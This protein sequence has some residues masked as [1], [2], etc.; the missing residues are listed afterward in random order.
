MNRRITSLCLLLSLLTLPL[1]AQVVPSS[2]TPLAPCRIFSSSP[3]PMLVAGVTYLDLVR[4][5]CNVPQTANA[6]ALSMIAS[7]A[8]GAG[9]LK[10]W[11]SSDLEPPQASMTYRGNGNDSSFSI[12]RLCYPVEEC[13]AD[14]IA[15]KVLFADSHI[16]LDVQGYFEPSQSQSLMSIEEPILN[17]DTSPIPQRDP[18]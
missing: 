16:L 13:A 4:G 10:V 7:G 5:S 2:Y 17:W 1:A 6:V 18:F 12:V 11:G 9:L 3:G 8:S 14:D 15:I